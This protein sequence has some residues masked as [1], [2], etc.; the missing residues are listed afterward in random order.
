MRR[1]R[2]ERAGGGESWLVW[3][4]GG[5]VAWRPPEP[6]ASVTAR[7]GRPRSPSPTIGLSGSPIVVRPVIVPLLSEPARR[8]V[9]TESA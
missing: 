3:S 7:D 5:E 8:P 6:V 9:G 4:T 1:Y 2:F